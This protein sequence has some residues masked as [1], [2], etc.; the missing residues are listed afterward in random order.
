[1]KKF[2]FFILITIIVSLNKGY[3]QIPFYELKL[4]NFVPNGDYY[5]ANEITFD[6]TIRSRDSARF[7]YAGGKFLINFN[8]VVRNGG[9]L[10]FSIAGPD[11]S[12]LP[13]NLRPVNPHIISDSNDWQLA[14]DMNSFPGADNGFVIPR[15]SAIKIIKLRLRTTATTFYMV[16]GA[17]GGT[18]VIY[19]EPEW[20]NQPPFIN[21]TNV[22]AYIFSINPV[23]IS[24]NGWH[25]VEYDGLYVN[26]VELKSFYSNVN[27]NTVTLN[28]VTTEEINNS[29]FEIERSDINEQWIKAGFVK[30]SGNTNEQVSYF[31]K[32][33][34]NTGKYFYRLK[35]IDFNGN[36]EYFTLPDEVVIGLPNR[37]ELSQNYPNP[38]NPVTNLDYVISKSGFVSLKIYD[39]TGSELAALVSEVK[40]PGYYTVKFNAVNLTSGIYFYRMTTKDFT[41]VKKLV[42]LK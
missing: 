36:F 17:L 14:L 30:G 2:I 23:N 8:Q 22:F 7:D 31:F 13:F 5:T 37:S 40:E 38:F 25:W 6:I 15:D 33:N 21:A 42:V 4:E 1:M 9:D 19:L 41:A 39:V 12:D 16:G 10:T 35:Q 27:Q 20:R 18:W 24:N 28:W 26:P 32:E 29:G 34:L 3:G 11:T